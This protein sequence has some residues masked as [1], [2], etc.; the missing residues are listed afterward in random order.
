MKTLRTT[1]FTIV[2]TIA[3]VTNVQ[4]KAKITT[5]ELI[6]G[7]VSLSSV[8]NDADYTNGDWTQL[9]KV[10]PN[11]KWKSGS[12]NNFSDVKQT[13]VQVGEYKVD[14]S[15]LGARSMIIKSIA[16]VYAADGSPSIFRDQIK[17]LGTSAKMLCEDP[18]SKESYFEISLAG[19]KPI[20][21]KLSLSSGSGGGTEEI[22]IGEV[23]LPD[24][25]SSKKTGS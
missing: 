22:E 6:N 7:L 25:C 4:A 20:V 5:A 10:F 23:S 24:G 18:D 9:K 1:A 16:S 3:I 12:D 21:A 17:V 13:T 11:A 2:I 15:A 8:P 14:I 19:L